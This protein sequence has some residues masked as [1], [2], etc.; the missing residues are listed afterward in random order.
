MLSTMDYNA[1]EYDSSFV[2]SYVPEQ[3]QQQGFRSPKTKFFKWARPGRQHG[4][5]DSDDEEEGT[6]MDCEVD[7]DET[8]MFSGEDEYFSDASSCTSAYPRKAGAGTDYE[9]GISSGDEHSMLMKGP[10]RL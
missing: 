3:Q 7:D 2:G 10:E 9:E 4:G 6:D 8:V 5:N 1:Q